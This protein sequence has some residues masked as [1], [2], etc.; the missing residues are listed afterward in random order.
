MQNKIKTMGCLYV[1]RLFDIKDL[2]KC[3]KLFCEVFNGE[4]WNDQWLDHKAREYLLDFVYTPGF[5]GLVAIQEEEM[6]GFICGYRKKWW[7]NDEFFVNEMCV[8][9]TFQGQGIGSKMFESLERELLE[10]NIKV[11]TL[12]T[13]RDVPAEKFYKKNGFFEIN[14][15]VFFAKNIK[16]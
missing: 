9:P 15:I 4:P 1:I 14:R 11:I 12:L 5:M 10:R 7:E 6:I 16:E 13:D 2:D 8:H 3:T